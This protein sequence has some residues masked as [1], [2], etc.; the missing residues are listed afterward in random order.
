MI[1]G[2]SKGDQVVGR[3]EPSPGI[4]REY[5]RTGAIA[6]YV[7][8]PARQLAPASTKQPLAHSA[9]LPTA[10]GTAWQALFEYGNLQ[11]DQTV[12]IHA[13]AGGVGSF[14]VQLVKLA[15][16][17]VI[18]TVSEGKY[19]LVRELGA[20]EVIDYQKT[21]FS[22]GLTGIDFVL[23]TV[24]GDTQSRSYK[25]LR[26]GGVLAAITAPVDEDLAKQYRVSASRVGHT[27]D[28]SRLGIIA[29]LVDNGKLR[30]VIDSL[31]H[32]ENAQEALHRVAEGRASGKV[33]ITME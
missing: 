21:D 17:R 12:L 10:A 9:A 25:V 26:P 6:E 30:I 2:W 31:F 20:D 11:A 3:F 29:S 32:L 15:G 13:A 16:A 14:A 7:A 23:D 24:G 19:S 4:G 18:A 28:G 8:I 27:S 33:L 5:S 1:S 22:E